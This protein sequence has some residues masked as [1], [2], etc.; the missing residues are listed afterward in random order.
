M[1]FEILGAISP[2]PLRPALEF[3]KCPAAKAVWPRIRV[4][5][6][7]GPSRAGWEHSIPAVEQLRYS[8]TFRTLK[9]KPA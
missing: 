3:A 8:I 7:N 1:H 2:K 4:D 6:H 5:A 9:A